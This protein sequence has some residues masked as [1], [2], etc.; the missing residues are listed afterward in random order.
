MCSA[1]HGRSVP[2][3]RQ[4]LL[5]YHKIWRTTFFG[6]SCCGLPPSD[7]TNA[8]S[9][10]RF[11][12]I[13][14]AGIPRRHLKVSIAAG[15][16]YLFIWTTEVDGIF[17]ISV[18]MTRKS[19]YFLNYFTSINVNNSNIFTVEAKITEIFRDQK[20]SKC[21]LLTNIY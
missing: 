4:R 7:D 18:N 14:G 15:P 20:K 9:G 1:P 21:V 10:C 5:I 12:D 3:I 13:K 19:E 11:A 6:T 17:L 2:E 16:S 8:V